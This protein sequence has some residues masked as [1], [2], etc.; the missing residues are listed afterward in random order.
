MAF[1]TDA[2][3]AGAWVLP[4]EA[5]PVA[6]ILGRRML[7]EGVLVPDLFWHEI[8]NL[9]V[10]SL[11]RGRLSADDFWIQ[12]ARLERMPVRVAPPSPSA[13]ILERAIKHG[14]T[15]YDAAYLD[16]A[17]AHSMPLATFDRQLRAAAAREGIQVLP[18]QVLIETI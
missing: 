12:L 1:V 3:V 17:V 15:A 10:L 7:A 18:E 14:L 13:R 16:L 4:D 11:K 5:S 8:R 6:T 9:L 2:S